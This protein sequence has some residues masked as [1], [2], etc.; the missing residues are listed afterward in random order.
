MKLKKISIKGIRSYDSEEISFPDGSLLLAGDIGSGKTTILLAIEYALFGLQPGQKGS[1]LLRNN[2]SAGEV[3][4]EMEIDGHSVIIERKLKRGPKTISNESSAITIDGDRFESSITEIKTKIIELLNYPQEYIKKN[5]V[6][7]RYTVYTPQEQMKQIILEDS[8]K[9][10][11][12]LRHIFGI[13]K[14]RRIR[15]NLIIILSHIKDNTKILQGEIKGL[16]KLKEDLTFKLTFQEEMEEKISLAKEKLEGQKYQTHII[17]KEEEDLEHK[18]KRK[19]ALKTEIE[20]TEILCTAKMEAIQLLKREKVELDRSVLDFKDSFN[21][22][23]FNQTIEKIDLKSTLIS[24]LNTKISS[25]K[26]EIA[27]QNRAKSDFDSKR[28]RIYKIDICPTCLQDV[29]EFHKHNIIAEAD[30]QASK[31]QEKISFYEKEIEKTEKLFSAELLELRNLEAKK[32]EQNLIKSKLP[33]LESTKKKIHDTKRSIENSERDL[34]LLDK[35]QQTLKEQVLILSK[36]DNLYRIKKEEL[37][38]NLESEKRTEIS[39]AELKKE[40]EILKRQILELEE[41][42]LEKEQ[43]KESLDNLLELN[44]WLSS[45]FLNLIDFIEKNVLMKLRQEFSKLFSKWFN[46]LVSDY[47]FSV[48]LDES[49]TPIISHSEVEMDYSALSGGERTAV[50]LAYR[51]A[52]NQ[53]VNSLLSK[54]KT[55]DLVIL[56]EPTDGFSEA[57]LNK[58]REVLSELNI[59][60]LIIVSHEPKIEDF[61]DHVLKIKKEGNVSKIEY[62]Q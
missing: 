45:N 3:S 9:R 41:Q 34:S 10:L 61:V 17:K 19:D 13:D 37:K 26:A 23:D 35:H 55:H 43:K 25:L 50:A 8:E 44:D 32:L 20:K 12:L 62:S 39:L 2:A 36:F 56:D 51:L 47:S 27:S 1:T 38:T 31:I 42:I 52:L 15:E 28:D 11:N 5:N 14:Y 29:P 4:L 54:I 53:T 30:S 33:Y 7:Y 48:H 40:V 16:D 24:E 59:G 49:F 21:E 6:L 18:T 58:M 57:Q 60:Q 46:T 22:S